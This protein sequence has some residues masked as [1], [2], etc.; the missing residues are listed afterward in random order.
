MAQQIQ[1]LLIDD[2]DG[3]DADETVSFS[4]DGAEY[5]I[6][7]TNAHASE[8]RNILAPFIEKARKPSSI[9]LPNEHRGGDNRTSREEARQIRDWAKQKGIEVTDRG[10]IPRDLAEAYREALRAPK[11]T[12]QAPATTAQPDTSAAGTA[13]EEA[14]SSPQEAKSAGVPAVQ[15]SS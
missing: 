8:M 6:D 3:S 12:A 10:R 9:R 5:V 4:L 15:F 1:T 7:L 13:A 11:R 2:I 14:S